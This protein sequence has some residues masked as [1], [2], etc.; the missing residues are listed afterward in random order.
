[1]VD[2]LLNW[3]VYQSLPTTKEN[4]RYYDILISMKTLAKFKHGNRRYTQ[5]LHLSQQD[6]F[7]TPGLLQA[8]S[9]FPNQLPSSCYR[10]AGHTRRTRYCT[11]IGRVVDSC[12]GM[13]RI[14][15]RKVNFAKHTSSH[16]DTANEI[17]SSNHRIIKTARVATRRNDN[18]DSFAAISRRSGYKCIQNV[19]VQSLRN[20][21][22]V[23]CEL[24]IHITVHRNRF[25][26]N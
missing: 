2:H 14:R 20:T 3:S 25:I 24:Y 21:E 10:S 22:N 1:M 12:A 18:T 6:P 4:P 5:N 15:N 23:S 17:S 9:Y 8:A 11:L 19:Q 13:R 26:F 16:W 7:V